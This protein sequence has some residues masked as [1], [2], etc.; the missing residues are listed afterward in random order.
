MREAAAVETGA[1]LADDRISLVELPFGATGIEWGSDLSFVGVYV[2]EVEEGGAAERTG[3][4]SAGDQLVAINGT[5]TF[6]LPFDQVMSLLGTGGS[7]SIKLEFFTG[8]RGDL[9]SAAGITVSTTTDCTVVVKDGSRVVAELAATKGANLRDVL[10]EAGLDVYR[11]TTKWTNCNGKQMCGTCIV[12][13]EKGAKET[14][15]KS[16]DEAST[17]NLQQC[18]AGSRLSCVT[19]IYGDVTV[20]LQPDRKGGF[21]GSATSGSAW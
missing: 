20:S 19:Y 3:L 13:V 11:G 7:D 18:S 8:S 17:L 14:N 6:D 9:L 4:V 12:D 10:V 16:N 15:R 1:V 21:F 2:R 5:S